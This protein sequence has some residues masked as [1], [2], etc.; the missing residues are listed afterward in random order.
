MTSN[1]GKR[2][3]LVQTEDE[4]LFSGVWLRWRDL[5]VAERL[6]CAVTVLMPLWWALG[7]IPYILDLITLGIALCEWWRYR[8]LRLKRPSLVVLTLFAYYM[9]QFG[10]EFLLFFDAHPL[11]VL[12]LDAERKPINLIE[13]AFSVFSLPYLIW[14]IQSNNVRVRLQ[15]VAWA[16]SVSVVQMLAVWLVVHF[17]FSNAFYNPPRTLWAVL[18]GKSIQYVRGNGETNYLLLYGTDQAVGGLSRFY[19]FFHRP[20]TFALFVGVV[21]IL[22]LDIKNRLWSVLLLVASIFLIGLSGTRAVW[23]A[24]PVVL[25]ISFWY[26]TGKARGSW[27][28]FALIAIMSFV[29]LSLPPATNLIFNTYTDTATSI[30]NFRENSTEHRGAAYVGTLEKILDNPPNFLF[31]Y[32]VSGPTVPGTEIEIGSHSFILGSLLYKGG[33]VSSGLFL[34]FWA[35]LITWLYRTRMDRPVCCFL[36]LLL[37]TITFATMLLSYIA[38]MA[39]L[40]S[41]LLRRPAIKSLSGTWKR[42]SHLIGLNPKLERSLR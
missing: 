29:T 10:G 4:R 38:P 15:V 36:I 16:F 21:G 2:I 14:Y 27:L 32:V 12:P 35:S 9:Y 7:L 40:L 13:S 41:M 25:F 34:T 6:V 20:E 1:L 33:L 19:S 8:K 22:A 31:G 18:T 37:L 11:A 3:S 26:T 28:L 24:F 5:N 30:A 23:I 42:N 17:V 39:I